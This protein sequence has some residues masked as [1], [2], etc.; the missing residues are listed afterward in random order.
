MDIQRPARSFIQV[1]ASYAAYRAGQLAKSTGARRTARQVLHSSFMACSS[2][3]T[4]RSRPHESAYL[5]ETA[6]ISST[7]AQHF[8]MA[9]WKPLKPMLVGNWC[10][11]TTYVKKRISR[12]ALLTAV[13]DK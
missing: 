7:S 4:A 8:I 10:G 12:P 13:A 1:A 11:A 5:F 9:G 6:T 3:S 2:L